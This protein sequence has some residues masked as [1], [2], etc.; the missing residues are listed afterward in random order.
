M[1]DPGFH[2]EDTI[3]TPV[4]IIPDEEVFN[5]TWYQKLLVTLGLLCIMAMLAIGGMA[6][7][8]IVFLY[9]GGPR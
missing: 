3:R 1:I 6:I 5:T 7:M 4:V 8:Y 9:Q 2:S